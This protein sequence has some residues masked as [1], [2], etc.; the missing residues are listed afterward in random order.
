M[1]AYSLLVTRCGDKADAKEIKYMILMG[2][3]LIE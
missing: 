1:G 2:M 3:Y